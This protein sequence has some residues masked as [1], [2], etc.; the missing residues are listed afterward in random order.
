MASSSRSIVWNFMLKSVDGTKSTCSICN[1]SFK[2]TGS[3][4]TMRKHLEKH[5]PIQLEELTKSR[6]KVKEEST[7]RQLKFQ[8]KGSQPTLREAIESKKPYDVNG[9]KKRNQD[10]LLAEMV[11]RD[12]QPFSIV[13][14]IGFRNYSFGLDPRYIIPSRRT[15]TRRLIPE[16]YSESKETLMKQLHDATDI[17]LTTDHWSSKRAQGFITVTAHFINSDWQLIPCVLDT[18]RMTDSVTAQALAD[19]ISSI[20]DRWSITDKVRTIVTDN[21]SNIKLC[22]KK[23]NKNWLPCVGHNFN[24]IVHDAM[25]SL[26]ADM[27]NIKAKSK[28]IVGHFKHSTKASD[29]LE[30]IQIAE[31]AEPLRLT[32]EVDTRWNS[33]LFMFQRLI[34]IYP[35]VMSALM[36]ENRPDLCLTD[37]DLANIKQLIAV[38]EPFD[39]ATRELSADTYPTASKVIT[40]VDM[41][42]K[43]M[44]NAG[45]DE[46]SLASKLKANLSARFQENEETFELGWA[47]ATFL[48]PRFKTNGFSCQQKYENVKDHLLNKMT[49]VQEEETQEET[50][51]IEVNEDSLW[52]FFDNKV[53]HMKKTSTTSAVKPTKEMERYLEGDILSRSEDPLKWWKMNSISFPQLADLA[54]N[55]L[56]CPATSTSS[57]RLFSKAGEL[58]CQRRSNL[59]PNKINM[60]LFLNKN[61]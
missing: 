27:K 44:E 22:V 8:E 35:F 3:T 17:H 38:L 30:K 46:K 18:E 32:Q 5:H 24:L 57:E 47:A 9:A 50:Q 34:K 48:D 56:A 7:A 54:K 1:A 14:D 39:K 20:M 37:G 11:C 58:V 41:L 36:K 31:N 42:G 19:T 28:K 60:V 6:V 51:E 49:P 40:L 23:L 21:A 55:Y 52:K 61:L 4:T 45:Q 43:W 26:S 53:K 15:L 33:T 12:L 16:L 2:N 29:C 25:K 13:E 10:R 59:K